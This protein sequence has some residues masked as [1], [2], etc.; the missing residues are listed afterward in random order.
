MFVYSVYFDGTKIGSVEVVGF[1]FSKE[2][3]TSTNLRFNEIR[4]PVRSICKTMLLENKSSY[5][6]G[7]LS[8]ILVHPLLA[9]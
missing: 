4:Y 8:V 9:A 5:Y 2:S 7:D 6:D 1:P 3:Y